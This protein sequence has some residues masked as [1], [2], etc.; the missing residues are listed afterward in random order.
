MSP[1][2]AGAEAP[3]DAAQSRQLE[4]LMRAVV[5]RAWIAGTLSRAYLMIDAR[6]CAATACAIV[7]QRRCSRA[8]TRGWWRRSGSD[9]ERKSWSSEHNRKR[10]FRGRARGAQ[11]LSSLFSGGQ[12]GV[13]RDTQRGLAKTTWSVQNR[14][15]ASLHRRSRMKKI[16]LERTQL[17]PL[18]FL[19]II[20]KS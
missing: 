16:S 7:P 11:A 20:K 4:G 2:D 5:A 3:G 9:D 12:R 14:E 19:V 18:H 10:A 17:I 1:D 15:L 8:I 13:R 6:R